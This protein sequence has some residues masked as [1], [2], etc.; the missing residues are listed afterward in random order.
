M[1]FSGIGGPYFKGILRLWGRYWV[2]YFR[3][4]QVS[5]KACVLSCKK[6]FWNELDCWREA[7]ETSKENHQTFVQVRRS[8]C[9]KNSLR[10]KD[11]SMLCLLQVR[12][13]QVP[14]ASWAS[15]ISVVLPQARRHRVIGKSSIWGPTAWLRFPR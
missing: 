8:V 12:H 13:F 4:P 5:F 1:G 11:T 2:P 10:R 6:E 3:K 15:S 9:C 14:R 7:A